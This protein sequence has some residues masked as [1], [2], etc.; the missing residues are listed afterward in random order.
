MGNVYSFMNC[1]VWN[2]QYV[3]IPPP[4]NKM[5]GGGGGEVRE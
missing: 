5:G 2:Y 4:P 3:E 1:F